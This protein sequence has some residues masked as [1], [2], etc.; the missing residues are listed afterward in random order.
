MVVFFLILW[1]SLYIILYH[2]FYIT[3]CHFVGPELRDSPDTCGPSE[4]PT[5]N[6]KERD[7]YS[8]YIEEKKTF[9]TANNITMARST[10]CNG[11]TPK[12]GHVQWH[13]KLSE[14]KWDIGL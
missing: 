7:D 3:N 4:I 5:K 1:H 12:H 6:M 11:K 8:Q 9:Q 13:V 2:D 14:G 10:L